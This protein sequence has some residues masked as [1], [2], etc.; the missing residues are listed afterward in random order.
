[1]SGASGIRIVDMPD[2]GAMD[3][4]SSVVGERAGS[5]RFAATALRDYLATDEWQAGTVTAVG[6]GLAIVGATLV[7]SGTPVATDHLGWINV[8][9]PAYG[10]A[11]NGTHD[12]TAA[13][14]AAANAIAS[15]GGVLYF[16]PALVNYAV[17]SGVALK[18]GTTVIGCGSSSLMRAL[19]TMTINNGADF[20]R[21]CFFYNANGA[22][23]GHT[24]VDH[25]ISVQDMAFDMTLSGN[26]GAQHCI[27]FGQVKNT[28]VYRCNFLN[29]GDAV[30]HIG[31]D[32]T[33]C[34]GCRADGIW[35]AAWDHWDQALNA[36][37]LDCTATGQ[38]NIPVVVS[39]GTCFN[40]QDTSDTASLSSS[41]YTVSGCTFNG[42]GCAILVSPLGVSH[43]DSV[44]AANIQGNTINGQGAG[45]VVGG[46]F[47]IVVTGKGGDHVIAGN[48]ITGITGCNAI[49]VG[50]DATGTPDVVTIANNLINACTITNGLGSSA[51]LEC[52]A[53]RASIVGN[54]VYLGTAPYNIYSTGA[55]C[56]ATGNIAIGASVQGIL[57]NGLYSSVLAQ[58]TTGNTFVNG[59]FGCTTLTTSDVAF[60]AGSNEFNVVNGV[61]RN[62]RVPNVSGARNY[63]S[64]YA[65][66]SYAAPNEPT[67]TAEGPDANIGIAITPKGTGLIGLGASIVGSAGTSVGYF[68]V[69]IGGSV[70]KIQI[71]NP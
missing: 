22:I 21:G 15:G 26:P 40:A 24:I 47:G 39:Y 19:S 63:L 10:A 14:Q 5:G 67:L 64:A 4:S 41:N 34:E 62:F 59:A 44:Y 29:A 8:T 31:C 18:S 30:A 32:T 46:Q 36:K 53:T 2:L 9:D 51:Q 68:T 25:D 54:V 13:I 28:R 57:V 48:L 45:T 56:F 66:T 65:G 69:S 55:Q 20:S 33:L 52:S 43:P 61:Q 60:P 16:P 1:M 3:D 7:A 50:T 42:F 35:N 38:P 12:D 70:V 27:R 58:D 6:P 37:V 23:D 71:F 49:H 17:S 11:G